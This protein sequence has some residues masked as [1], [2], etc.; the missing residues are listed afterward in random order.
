MKE[1]ARLEALLLAP[2]YTTKLPSAEET[3]RLTYGRD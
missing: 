1:L 2:P 3:P